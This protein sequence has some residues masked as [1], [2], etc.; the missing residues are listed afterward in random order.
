MADFSKWERDTL[1]RFAEEA[2]AENRKLRAQHK[3]L[4]D[5]INAITN[6]TVTAV[7]TDLILEGDPKCVNPD[8]S[9]SSE[10]SPPL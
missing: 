4:L 7:R 8:S 9:T 6:L 1:V 2:S 10:S 3:Q 5:A